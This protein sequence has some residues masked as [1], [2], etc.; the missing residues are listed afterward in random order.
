MHLQ[1]HT[2]QTAAEAFERF[3][4]AREARLLIQR[5]WHKTASDGRQLACAL[6]VLGPDVE[7]PAACPA[8]VMPRWLAQMVPTFFDGMDF[9]A[10]VAWGERFYAELARLD[11]KVPFSVIHDWQ[12]NVV[13][14]LGV[15]WRELCKVSTDA[16]LRVKALHQ[17]AMTG[18]RARRAEWR[19]ALHPMYRELYPY[20][21]ANAY[22]YADAYADADG[23]GYAY[24]YAYAQKT[25]CQ[26]AMARLANGMVE[27][28]ARLS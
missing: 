1:P 27:C 23:Y 20:A 28:L 7:G 22:A 24:A 13:C 19:E 10:A 6:G 4:A 17:R 25:R 14:P 21:Y 12:A 8:A 15:E 18:D 9:D 26:E 5:A 2:A 16:V 11:G 3:H